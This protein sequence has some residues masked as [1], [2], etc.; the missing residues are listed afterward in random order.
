MRYTEKTILGNNVNFF[1]SIRTK[2]KYIAN[3]SI[4]NT[5]VF[6]FRC[7]IFSIVPCCLGNVTLINRFRFDTSF[8]CAF[9]LAELQLF[10]VQIYNTKTIDLSSGS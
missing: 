8:Y 4:G 5:I 10:T 6:F 9:P 3:F 1:L 2:N 7:S